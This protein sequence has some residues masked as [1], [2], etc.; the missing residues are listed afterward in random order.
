MAKHGTSLTIREQKQKRMSVLNRMAIGSLNTAYSYSNGFN[1]ET[2]HTLLFGGVATDLDD[3]D[4]NK[5]ELKL[6]V[7][8]LIQTLKLPFVWLRGSGN[9]GEF[10]LC[11]PYHDWEWDQWEDIQ[12]RISSGQLK[13]IKLIKGL[14]KNVPDLGLLD[15]IEEKDEPKL[16]LKFDVDKD[17]K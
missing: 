11:I 17:D 16:E 4:R 10:R 6:I 14:R 9:K 8:N 3:Y 2:I 1:E 15:E 13:Y 12:T 7:R 5:R